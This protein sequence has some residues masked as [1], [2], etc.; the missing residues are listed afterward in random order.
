MEASTSLAQGDVAT[1]NKFPMLGEHTQDVLTNV[2]SLT[3][4]QVDELRAKKVIA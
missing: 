2:L 1:S 4:D 3:L